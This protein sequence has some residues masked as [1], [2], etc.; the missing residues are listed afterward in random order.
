MPSRSTDTIHLLERA[1][2]GDTH[3]RERLLARHREHIRRMVVVRMDHR[4]LNRV[5]PSDIVQETL[6]IAHRRLDAYLRD[7]PIPFQAW[8]RQLAWDQIV[9]FQR[10]HLYA[11]RRSRRREED[12]VPALSDESVARIATCVLDKAADPLRKLVHAEMRL[13]VRHAIDRLPRDF[14]EVLILRHL[15]R[16]S[17]AETAEILG[18]G[19][20]ATKMRHL[21]ALERLK[22]LL[23]SEFGEGS[24]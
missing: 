9:S 3:A 19:V 11:R 24:E 20:S 4:L 21:R 22:G 2:R 13:R 15:E 17:V 12:L 1:S 10:K 6:I 18:I 14:R 5:D 8:L 23:D 16:L 7:R